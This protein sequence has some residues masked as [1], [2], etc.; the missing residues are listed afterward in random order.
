MDMNRSRGCVSEEHESYLNSLIGSAEYMGT[1]AYW[2]NV[3]SQLYT[4]EFRHL[5]ASKTI[6]LGFETQSCSTNSLGK[7]RWRQ[8]K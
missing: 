3:R 8:E 7:I 6:L 2:Q 1:Y 5:N 4:C